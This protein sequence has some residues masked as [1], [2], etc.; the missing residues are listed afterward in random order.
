MSND[1]PDPAR[2]MRLVTVDGVDRPEPDGDRCGGGV[3][4][5]GCGAHRPEPGHGQGPDTST[6]LAG[7]V[8]AVRELL[9]GSDDLRQ[10]LEDELD[11]PP[12]VEPAVDCWWRRDGRDPRRW[13]DE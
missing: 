4:G 9:S 3:A 10:A 2:R 8:A 11:A 13:T 5:R 12:P 1:D 6:L 7:A